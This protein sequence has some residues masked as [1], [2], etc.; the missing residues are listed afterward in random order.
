MAWRIPVSYI[1]INSDSTGFW[2]LTKAFYFLPRALRKKK[3]IFATTLDD[4]KPSDKSQPFVILIRY[5]NQ[6]SISITNVQD[7]QLIKRKDSFWLTVLVWFRVGWPNYSG[8]W[9]E[10]AQYEGAW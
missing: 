1:S 8:A 2:I 5:I 6:L 10:A 3:R 4:G 9:G 7:N